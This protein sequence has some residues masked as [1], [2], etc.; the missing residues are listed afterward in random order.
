MPVFTIDAPEG[1]TPEAKRRVLAEI[2]EALDETYHFPDTRGW[3]REYPA[4]NLS[5]D[6][7]VG[8]EPA[9]PVCSIEAPEL[10]SLEAKRKLVQR[11][12]V[13]IAEGYAGIANTGETLVLINTYPLDEV[14][15]R[16]GLQSDNP[17]IVAAVAHLNGMDH[18]RL[19]D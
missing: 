11:I 13:A 1:A 2:S 14:G 7:R 16:S 5:V 3:L 9:R 18:P 17:E 8:D 4:G 15:W 19:H 6:G 12:E 10:R